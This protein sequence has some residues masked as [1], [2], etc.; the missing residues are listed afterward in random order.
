MAY[1]DSQASQPA[2]KYMY[3][4]TSFA[5]YNCFNCLV[6]SLQVT[7]GVSADKTSVTSS[8][9]ETMIYKTDGKPLVSSS[10]KSYSV[11]L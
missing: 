6:D 7:P 5:G 11:H 4:Y 3:L 10:R 9:G 2:G 1:S 8:Q